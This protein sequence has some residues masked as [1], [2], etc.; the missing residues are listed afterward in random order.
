MIQWIRL[1]DSLLFLLGSGKPFEFLMESEKY[2]LRLFALNLTISDG[3]KFDT[4]GVKPRNDAG[5]SIEVFGRITY[6]QQSFDVIE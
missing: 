2:S 3:E 4:N 6:L 5:S 1:R